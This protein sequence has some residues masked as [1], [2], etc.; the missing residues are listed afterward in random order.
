MDLLSKA[1]RATAAEIQEALPSPPSYSA[2]RAM[3]RILEE[4]VY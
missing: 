4:T 2:T 3:L 1:G